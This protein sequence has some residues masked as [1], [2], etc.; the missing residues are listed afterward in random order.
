MNRHFFRKIVWILLLIGVVLVGFAWF[1]A[2]YAADPRTGERVNIY[3]E[4]APKHGNSPL[5]ARLLLLT[6]Y[7]WAK[8]PLAD[9]FTAPMGAG[10]G[11]F[12]YDAQSFG[13]EN[14]RRGGK[15][16][17][18]DWNGI[19]GMNTDLGDPVYAA[20][21]GRVIYAGQPSPDWGNVVVLLH[22]LPD[23]KLIQSLYAHLDKILVRVGDMVPRGEVIGKVGDANGNYPAHL[24]FEVIDSSMNEAGLPA[25]GKKTANRVDPH[26]L[27][28]KY[29]PP[30]G[31]TIPDVIP[32][33]R[34]IQSDRD[35]EGIQF[36]V[37]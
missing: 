13:E 23:G 33:L 24:H 10:N 19:G 37:K 3:D 14:A 30:A 6:P 27:F 5:D 2:R 35:L 28:R 8:A 1:S 31:G 34:R 4:D 22:R 16:F 21:R 25:Y 29:A 17:G 36:Q 26:E 15:H 32:E 20:G 9:V 11:A 18:Q 12:T 7:D